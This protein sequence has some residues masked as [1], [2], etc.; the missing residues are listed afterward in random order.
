MH[1]YTDTH[2]H[3][4]THEKTWLLRL[5]RPQLKEQLS[6]CNHT[7]LKK[8][9]LNKAWN[10][11]V[12]F[13]LSSF[14]LF[15]LYFKS[16]GIS[17]LKLLPSP[18]WMELNY[19]ERQWLILS[20]HNGFHG[21][22]LLSFS[23]SLHCLVNQVGVL[24]SVTQAGWVKENTNKCMYITSNSHRIVSSTSVFLQLSH[25]HLQIQTCQ[26]TTTLS[27]QCI[28]YSLLTAHT[29]DCLI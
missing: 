17:N 26:P 18:L 27:P 7:T 14:T 1:D 10:E 24:I 5:H 12:Q 3:A 6:L 29:A 20:E 23:L 15:L 16:S 13:S 8:R 28:F 2:T 11:S 22:Y 21:V 19:T 9:Y 25:I 4:H